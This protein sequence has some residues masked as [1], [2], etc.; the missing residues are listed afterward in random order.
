MQGI[1]SVFRGDTALDASEVALDEADGA[2]LEADPGAPDPGA[3]APEP[4][5]VGG[6][7]GESGLLQ[8][9]LPLLPEVLA[10]SQSEPPEDNTIGWVPDP[11]VTCD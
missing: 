5:V 6:P 7:A 4:A 2:L 1:L 10:P 9:L 3:P 8:L 11:L